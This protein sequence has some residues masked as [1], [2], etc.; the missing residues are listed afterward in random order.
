[1]NRKKEKLLCKLWGITVFLLDSLLRQGI[2]EALEA[3]GFCD[4]II[5][6]SKL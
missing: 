6:K 5:N 2:I 4:G 1:M 3:G